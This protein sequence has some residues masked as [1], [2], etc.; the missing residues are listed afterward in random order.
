MLIFSLK[1]SIHGKDLY[2]EVQKVGPILK[3]EIKLNKI[4]FLYFE[5]F[6][7]DPLSPIT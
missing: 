2:D 1:L 7:M 5:A 4:K 3:V 6:S